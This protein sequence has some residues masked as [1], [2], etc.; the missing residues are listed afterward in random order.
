MAKTIAIA[1]HKGGVS[2]TVMTNNLGHALA[3]AGKKVLL[4]D[5]DPQGNLSSANNLRPAEKTLHDL[6]LQGNSRALHHLPELDLIPANLHLSLAEKALMT[7]GVKGFKV[8]EKALA[9][10]K[11]NYDYILMDCPPSVGMIVSNAFV[12]ADSV[13][14][15]VTP[16]LDAV[17]GVGSILQLISDC[18]ELNSDLQIEGIVF[19]RVKGNTTLHKQLIED[20]RQTYGDLRVFDTTLR[21]AIVLAE[22][23]MVKESVFGYAPESVATAEF[24]HLCEELLAH[25]P[26]TA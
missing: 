10:Y 2:K 18:K 13:L 7:D 1:N 5:C 26:V 8:L 3:R 16:E 20:V 23:A 21:E 6:L 11:D 4:V 15:P 25:Q 24:K 17:L 12:A 14:I 9:P 22:T 19:T